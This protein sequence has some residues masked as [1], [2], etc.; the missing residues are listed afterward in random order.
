MNWVDIY[1]SKITTAEDAATYIKSGDRVYIGA[2]C[3]VPHS[4]VDAMVGCAADLWN[5]EITHLLTIGP[6]PYAKPEMAEHFRHNAVFVGGN[7]REAINSGRGDYIPIY[8]ADVPKLYLQGHLPLDVALVSLSPPDEHGFCS[9]GIEVGCTKPAAHAAK[10]VIAEVNTEMPRTL[11]DSFIHVSKVDQ[12]VEVSRPLDVLGKPEISDVHR[13]IGRYIADL[14][15]DG[16][17]LQMGIGAIPDA[18]LLFLDEKE[19]LGV[20]TEMFSDG[21]IELIER[22]IVTNDKKT[23]HPGKAIVGFLLGSRR[24]YEF[25]DNNALIEF[26]PTDYV[27]NPLLISQNDKM[28][29]INS[30]IQVDITGQVSADSIGYYIYSGFGGQVDFMRGA[31]RSSGGKPITALPSTAKGG[32]VSRIVPHLDEGAGVVTNRA[33]VHYVVTEYGVAYL[34]GKNLRQRVRALIDLAHPNFRE[35]LLR[36]AHEHNYL[37]RATAVGRDVG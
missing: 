9:F 10:K 30:A 21:L 2:G 23:V 13:R 32:A 3:G 25:V 26:H 20:H 16:S 33:D 29:A 8:L 11:G 28:V 27:N 6:A 15:E 5:V 36:F 4:L 1:K 35:D 22:G 18:V 37:P 19:D 24:L 7:V 12:F 34:Y 17:T 14:I 31:A